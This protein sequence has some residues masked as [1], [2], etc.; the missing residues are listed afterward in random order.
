M[1]TS[2]IRIQPMNSQNN[3]NKKNRQNSNFMTTESESDI[4]TNTNSLLENNHKLL[5]RIIQNSKLRI[6]EQEISMKIEGFLLALREKILFF[7]KLCHV[8]INLETLKK[9]LR[10]QWVSV[11]C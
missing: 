10:P 9:W 5:E 1:R 2:K 4:E 3:K 7:D 11:L 8:D 6:K